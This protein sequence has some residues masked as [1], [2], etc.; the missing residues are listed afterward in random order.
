[1]INWLKSFLDNRTFGVARDSRWPTARKYHLKIQDK[2]QAC[3]K[4]KNL[5]VHHCTPVHKDPTQ[6][7]NPQNFITLCS[8]CHLLFGHLGSWYSY[9]EF[10]RE[11]SLVMRGKIL[12]RP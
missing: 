3:G 8:T 5:E 4:R 7:L 12:N 1:M 10:V 11:D 9:N 6:E 2:C